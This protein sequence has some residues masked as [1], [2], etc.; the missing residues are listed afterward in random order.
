MAS[1]NTNKTIF[2][3]AAVGVMLFLVWKLWPALNSALAGVS[4]G[5]GS[6]SGGGGVGSIG[7]GY[8]DSYI[9]QSQPSL[10]GSLLGSLGLNL[11]GGS[12]GGSFGGAGGG[13]PNT[14]ASIAS[15]ALGSGDNISWGPGESAYS[16]PWGYVFSDDGAPTAAQDANSFG[17]GNNGIPFND[18]F[19]ELPYG[20]GYPGDSASADTGGWDGTTD[21]YLT[22]NFGDGYGGGDDD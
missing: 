11:G 10:L 7:G 8:E 18:A 5:G 14:L 2:T 22:G 3:V 4:G 6:G 12:G 13:S 15:A 9:P 19:A 20:S 16:T 1:S 17:G 21:P